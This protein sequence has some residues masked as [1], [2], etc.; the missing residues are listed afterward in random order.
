MPTIEEKKDAKQLALARQEAEEQE[1]LKEKMDKAGLSYEDHELP[2]DDVV[3]KKSFIESLKG[4][5]PWSDEYYEA[6]AAEEE[7][8]N[9]KAIRVERARA[10]DMLAMTKVGDHEKALSIMMSETNNDFFFFNKLKTKW[11]EEGKWEYDEPELNPFGILEAQQRRNR[12][13]RAF[14]AIYPSIQRSRG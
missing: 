8:D 11:S 12:V 5:W 3:V 7:M 9:L 6:E 13:R 2:D 4:M 14:R 10:E 1:L